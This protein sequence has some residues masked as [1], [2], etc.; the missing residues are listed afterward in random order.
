MDTRHPYYLLALSALSVPPMNYPFPTPD[1][2]AEEDDA[3]IEVMAELS[4]QDGAADR[5]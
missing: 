1:L 5:P 4:H 3:E 2:S